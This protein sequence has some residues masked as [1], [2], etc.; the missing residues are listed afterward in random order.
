MRFAI[1]SALLA[2]VV[3][4][5]AAAEEATPAAKSDKQ[6]SPVIGRKIAD[7][8]LRDYR[9]KTYKL[10]DFADKKLVV[11]AVLGTEC[12]LAKLYAPRL[13]DLADEFE[14]QG[15]AFLGLD[16][17]RQDSLTEIGAY[18]RIHELQFPMLKDMGNEIADRLGAVRTPEVFVLDKDRVVRYW[19][20]IDDQYGIG[21]Q[22]PAPTRRDLKVAIDELLWGLPVSQAVTPA[23]G[24]F[25]GRV[26]KKP[27]QGDVTYSNQISRLLNQRC[28]SCHR[29]GEIAP[30]PLTSYEEAAGWADT[31]REVVDEGRMPPWFAD[32]KHGKFSNDA[33]L[34]AEEKQLVRDWVNNGCPEGDRAQLPEPPKFTVGW[35]IGEPDQV[36]YIADKP[37]DVQAEGVVAYQYFVVDPGFK[38]D[39]W[40]KMAEARPDNRAVVHHIVASF[41][42]G[43]AAGPRVG[44]RGQVGYAPG[45]PPAIYP[46]G[47][48]LFIPAGSKLVFQVHYTPNGS[49]QKD[50]SY[51]GLKF[52][53]PEEVK[54]R[55]GGGL[56][57]T[58]KFAIPPGDD[59]YE[60]QSVHTFG[61]AVRLVTLTPHMHLRGKAFRYEAEYPD[62]RRE[63]LLDIP[64]YDFNWQLRY[65]LA[66]PKL[67]PKGTKLIC[68]AHYDNSEENL[69][70]PNPKATVR[71]G[72]QTWDE[73]MIGYF[74]SLPVDGN[75]EEK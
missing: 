59:N 54:Q 46:E 69:S 50:R 16:A 62:G 5:Q 4:S 13:A 75:L 65:D 72:D 22:R 6:S 11:I 32:P 15:V 67:M 68:T 23:T 8:S 55:I 35:Q 61:S 43:G 18:V 33:R 66:E 40:I 44:E 34:S 2:V 41:R 24:C 25:V 74:T 53:K 29:P 48:A 36:I 47:A 63:I 20:R 14:S 56:V 31:I 52:A 42:T 71:W 28:V 17:N 7:F 21:V 73:M 26:S 10:S 39:K 51:I 45:M 12:P 49:P 1:L 58:A 38:E 19:G 60:T 27:P 57:A 70:N 30:F 37:V 9:G 64:R 3:A